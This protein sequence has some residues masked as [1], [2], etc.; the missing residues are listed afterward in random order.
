MTEYQGLESPG[1]TTDM[2]K[3]S[4]KSEQVHYETNAYS[5]ILDTVH[6]TI[7]IALALHISNAH[8]S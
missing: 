6:G 7:V 4:S 8:I 5:Y 2:N 3:Q 1:P